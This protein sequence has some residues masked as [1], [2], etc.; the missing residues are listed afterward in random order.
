MKTLDFFKWFNG[1]LQAKNTPAVGKDTAA[2]GRR[3]RHL[4]DAKK[5]EEQAVYGKRTGHLW[6]K[7]KIN[8][9]PINV[10]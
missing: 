9:G 8:M 10:W 1:H 5:R 7:S 3:K 4:W 6:A 2:G